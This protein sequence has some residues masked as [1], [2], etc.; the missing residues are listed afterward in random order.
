[1]GLNFDL[2]KT[3]FFRRYYGASRIWSP[4]GWP[5]PLIRPVILR[6]EFQIFEFWVFLRSF[7]YPNFGLIQR[8][9]PKY[10]FCS[11][12]LSH[13]F[14]NFFWLLNRSPDVP[15]TFV[16]NMM[17]SKHFF[18]NFEDRTKS[19]KW[20]ISLLVCTWGRKFLKY[21]RKQTRILFFLSLYWPK[22]LGP[23]PKKNFLCWSY[24]LGHFL[25]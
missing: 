19:K 2:E 20:K 12:F 21:K 7:F 23:W 25:G 11:Q 18:L 1:M 22:V 15:K 13:I 6:F 8:M 17:I 24:F 5:I 16:S 9:L 10:T 3:F 4:A 14:W